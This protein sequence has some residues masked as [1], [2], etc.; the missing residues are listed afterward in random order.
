MANRIRYKTRRY[1]GFLHPIMTWEYHCFGYRKGGHESNTV[2]DGSETEIRQVSD[3]RFES[4]TTHKSHVERYAFFKRHEEYPKNVLFV[5]LE[6][7]MTVVSYL[8]V[9]LGKFLI[10]GIFI[11]AIVES[12]DFAEMYLIPALTA[13]YVCSFI[14]PLA[15]FIVRNAL[16][17]D[18]K[19]DDICEENGWMKWS[20][21]KDE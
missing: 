12:F 16:G 3:T 18:E 20:E 2:Y 1:F 13:I 21:Y 9:F 19:L 5:L 8:R 11:S 17:L 6:F 4:T 14:I 15:G 10:A 7:L